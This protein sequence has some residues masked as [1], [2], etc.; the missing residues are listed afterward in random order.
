MKVAIVGSRDF[1]DLERVRNYV[2]HLS[3]TDVVISGGARG[4]D[5]TAVK[6]ARYRG[7]NTM[8]FAADWAGLGR[9]A[10][11]ARNV[12]IVQQADRVVAFWDGKSK[13]TKHTIDLANKVDKP[14]EIIST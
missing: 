11:Y 1:Q 7:M 5:Q 2:S 3:T 6:E 8:V 4:V 9:G 10:G 12:L 14:V 13:G